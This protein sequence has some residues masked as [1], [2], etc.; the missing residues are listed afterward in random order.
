MSTSFES[1][2]LHHY[3]SLLANLS[4]SPANCSLINVLY[5]KVVLILKGIFNHFCFHYYTPSQWVSGTWIFLD[6]S[7][8]APQMAPAQFSHSRGRRSSD[9]NLALGVSNF[10]DSRRGRRHSD[11]N[12]YF[13]SGCP[14]PNSARLM[15]NLQQQQD[16][17]AA[18][19]LM[20]GIPFPVQDYTA[21]LIALSKAQ[22]LVPQPPLPQSKGQVIA[23]GKGCSN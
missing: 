8:P 16:P 11:Q 6:L 10:Q 22:H 5:C 18:A 12:Q 23:P 14:E 21:Q 4:T 19:Q 20:Q 7:L 2:K 9:T 13:G 1:L 3:F 15:G 17:L